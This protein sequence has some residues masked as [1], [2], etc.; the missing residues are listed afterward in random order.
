M[1]SEIV[2]K[3]TYDEKHQGAIDRESRQ[4]LRMSS[5]VWELRK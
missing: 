3:Q 2:P 4:T 1:V 5:Y